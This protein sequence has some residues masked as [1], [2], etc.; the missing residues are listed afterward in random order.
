MNILVMVNFLNFILKMSISNLNIIFLAYLTKFLFLTKFI[1]A[2]IILNFYYIEIYIQINL[3]N[4]FLNSTI[5]IFHIKYSKFLL[6]GLLIL[7]IIF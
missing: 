3:Q 2:L 4:F 5:N 1:M 6:M 7:F